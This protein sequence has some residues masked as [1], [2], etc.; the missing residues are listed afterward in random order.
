[1]KHIKE[2]ALKIENSRAAA[3]AYGAIGKIPFLRKVTRLSLKKRRIV[4]ISV[5]L[6]VV[7]AVTAVASGF[8]EGDTEAAEYTEYVVS[9]GDVSVTISGSGAVEPNAQYNVV[10]LVEGDVLQDTF[11]E[12]DTVS[13]GALL[14]KIDSSD[15]EKTLEKANISYERSNMS[16]QKSMDA[17]NGLTVTAPISGRVTEVLIEKGGSVQNGARVATIADDSSLTARVS[18]GASDA[19]GLYVGEP[20]DVTVENTFEVLSGT[21]TRINSSKKILDGY[22]E[23]VDVEVT[24]D[25]PGALESGTYVTA[26]AGG[27][28]CYEGA[29]LEG[30]TEKVVT[31]KASGTVLKVYVSEGEYIS[32]GAEI[33]S[34]TSDSADEDLRSSELSLRESQ[35]SYE[36][37]QEQLDKYSITAPISGTVIEKDV[38]AGDTVESSNSGST[39][40]CV[41]ADMSLMKFTID[42][43]ELDIASMEEG[44]EVNITA[45]ALSGRTFTGHVSNIGIL[46]ITSNGVTSYPVEIAIDDGEDLWPGMN[47]TAEIVVNSVQNVLKI[48]VSAVNRG[49]L[50]LVKGATGTEDATGVEPNV[51]TGSK[52][53]AGA[54]NAEPNEGAWGS[55]NAGGGRNVSGGG[56]STG[57]AR[58]V[59]AGGVNAGGAGYSG[60]VS[61]GGISNVSGGGIGTGSARNASAG[62]FGQSSRAIDQ[63]TAPDG[64]KYVRVEL[65]IN[66]ETYIEVTSGLSEGDT[67]LVPVVQGSEETTAQQGN[68]FMMP[69]GGMGGPPEGGGFTRNTG[70]GTGG[71]GQYTRNSGGSSQ[72]N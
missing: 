29:A 35:L 9:R 71:G 21:I 33:A 45:D 58:N 20:A 8:F 65:G 34:L 2:G 43:D 30:K 51:G 15:M 46:G 56:I 32:Q 14:Y 13:K 22:V 53:A 67:I 60:N 66:D 4:F 41:I 12:G 11:E 64:A 48:P 47:V 62:G 70:G 25:N 5:F 52:D 72:G 55:G 28:D 42:V 49:N 24:V 37:T 39:T 44:Q 16:Y 19:E 54:G 3:G 38:K 36:S 57:G 23:V 27:V 59:S 10:S 26:S 40:L 68:V 69:G 18:F 61:G 7:L 63:S 6:V 17:Y 50:V 31:S 1:M